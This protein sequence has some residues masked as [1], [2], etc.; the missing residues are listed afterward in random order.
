VA[1]T[2]LSF[3]CYDTLVDYSTGKAASVRV[4]VRE[5]GGDEDAAEE[6]VQIFEQTEESL[7][8]S[9]AFRPLGEVLRAALDAALSGLEL[10]HD[11]ADGDRIVQSVR[12]AR[13][14]DDVAPALK[15]LRQHYKTA[16]LSNSEQDIIADNIA[17]IG[18]AFEQ[19][20][21]AQEVGCYKPDARMFQALLARCQCQGDEI[22]HIAQSFRH[23]I[24]PAHEL[25][26]RRVWINRNGLDGDDAYGPYD[27]LPDL[28]GLPALLGL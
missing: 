28:S 9:P 10:P 20:V 27:E 5:K 8:S 11:A 6:A 14:F 19:V 25:G 3:D 22:V 24:I 18:V 7:Q 26:W 17:R 1:I 2:Y 21:L 12:N 4:M 13:P 15:R 16:L 23:D